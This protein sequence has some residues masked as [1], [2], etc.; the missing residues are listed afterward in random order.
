V[1]IIANVVLCTVY[2]D[3]VTRK[4]PVAPKVPVVSACKELRP[5]MARIGEQQGFQF[6]VA[7][8]DFVIS[9]GT[10]DM[11]PFEHGFGL[12][13]KDGGSGLGITF[14]HFETP[15][16]DP[17]PTFLEHTEKQNIVDYTGRVVGVD[18]WGYLSTGE[19][20]REVRLFRGSVLAKYEFIN[21][22]EAEPW[23]R[24]IS[25]ACLIPSPGNTK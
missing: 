21:Q 16:V 4:V 11:P 2:F 1:V 7:A 15:L 17:A 12:H 18:R 3:W 19:R 23:D 25:S 5:G 14:R 24:V 13:S 9:E 8:K 20:W 6:D 10:Q 22:K